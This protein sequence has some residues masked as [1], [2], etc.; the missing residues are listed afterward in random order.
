MS[1]VVKVLLWFYWIIRHYTCSRFLMYLFIFGAFVFYRER[2]KSL[3]QWH[4]PAIK[5]TVQ[6]YIDPFVNKVNAGSFC[7]SVIHRTLTWTTGS[8]TYV[9]INLMLAYTLGGRAHRHRVSTTFFW[10]GKTILKKIVLLTGFEPRVIESWAWRST[11]TPTSKLTPK[12][13][14]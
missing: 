3:D 8:L 12:T 13:D 4:Y 6:K 10:L 1:R 2:G 7:I 14:L 5:F 9:I 11:V